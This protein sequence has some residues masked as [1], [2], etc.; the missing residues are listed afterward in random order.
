MET[1]IQFYGDF[2]CFFIHGIIKDAHKMKKAYKPEECEIC[3]R[4]WDF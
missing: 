4:K 2:K 1:I 3:G